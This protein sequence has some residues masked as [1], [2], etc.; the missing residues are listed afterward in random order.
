MQL[1]MLNDDGKPVGILT[2]SPEEIID[3]QRLIRENQ[4]TPD[5]VNNITDALLDAIIRQN[6]SGG[7]TP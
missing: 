1:V 4:F 2:G 7:E 6:Q 5:E 3:Y